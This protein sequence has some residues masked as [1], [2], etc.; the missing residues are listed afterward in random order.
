[1]YYPTVCMYMCVCMYT[2]IYIYIYVCVCTYTYI[3]IC[4]YVYI[5]IYRMRDCTSTVRSLVPASTQPPPSTASAGQ[6]REGL[7]MMLSDDRNP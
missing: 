5:Y 4:M 2:Y 7:V 3:Y 1:M 6:S